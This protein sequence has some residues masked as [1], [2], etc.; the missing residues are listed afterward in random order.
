MCIP[1]QIELNPVK[2]VKIGPDSA[3]PSILTLGRADDDVEVAIV[4]S[5]T[6]FP[7]R[8]PSPEEQCQS[9]GVFM[10]LELATQPLLVSHSP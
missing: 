6:S 4:A 9:L 10:T 2:M 1:T 7:W 3:V 5:H 8:P